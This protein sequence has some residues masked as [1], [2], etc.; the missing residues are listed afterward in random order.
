[1]KF[2]HSGKWTFG[3][4]ATVSDKIKKGLFA[5]LG[6]TEAPQTPAAIFGDAMINGE[7]NWEISAELNVEDFLAIQKEARENDNHILE[8]FQKYGKSLLAG[9][10]QILTEAKKDI[11]EW[12]ALMHEYNLQEKKNN[13]ETIMLNIKLRKE[14]KAAEKEAEEE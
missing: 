8:W 2:T 9:A 5:L 14:E 7:L 4:S 11:P 1:M 13:H 6:R 10:N 3:T 12:Q